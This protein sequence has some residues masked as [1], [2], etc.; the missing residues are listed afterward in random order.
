MCSFKGTARLV[1]FTTRLV[2]MILVI[3]SEALF[4][5]A[6]SV[7]LGSSRIGPSLS[8]TVL[9][10]TS[11]LRG[12]ALTFTAFASGASPPYSYQW[13]CD[14]NP[15]GGFA[16]GQQTVACSWSTSGTHNVKALIRDASG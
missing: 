10:P 12:A 11:G 16:S 13:Q 6:G 15:I 2:T 9:G 7:L 3:A 1:P 4:A 14:Y 8:V 5:G